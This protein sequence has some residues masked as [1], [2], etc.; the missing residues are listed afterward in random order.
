MCDVCTIAPTLKTYVLTDRCAV[1][2]VGGAPE[3]ACLDAGWLAPR[4]ARDDAR[5]SAL[6]D[7]ATPV[8]ANVGASGLTS[9]GGSPASSAMRWASVGAADSTTSFR[10]IGWSGGA[11]SGT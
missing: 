8:S 11:L 6:R 1:V 3:L 5:S 10:R 7:R 4:L 2:G 9:G